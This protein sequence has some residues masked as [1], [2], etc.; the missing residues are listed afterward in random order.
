MKRS[1]V[2]CF[3]LCTLIISPHAF[4]SGVKLIDYMVSSSGLIELLGQ[5]GIKG[6]E[7]KQVESYVFSSL[8]SFGAGK[9]I[10]QKELS[11]IL[12]KMPV[13]GQDASIRKEL[14]L[15]LDKSSGDLKKD[16]V[17][18]AINN[19]IY[20]ANRH[21]KSVIIT[22]A[23]CVSDNLSKSGF[24]FTVENIK[25]AGS[26]KLLNDVIPNNPKDL[27]VF[28]SARV[29]RLGL[30]DYSKVTPEMVSPEEEKTLALFL[31]SYESG[32][33]E[34]KSFAQS[35][36]RLSTKGGKTNLFDASNPNKLWKLVTTDLSSQEIQK[37]STVL[38]EVDEVASKEK[39]KVEDAFNRVLRKKSETSSELLEK[40]KQIK[41]R[42]CFFK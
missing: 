15:L 18:K 37:I 31:A 11:D 41:N 21:G 33:A 4:A 40:Y 38:G 10:S 12:S 36:K 24:K 19:I 2:F 8:N 23:E 25:N 1:L 30:G 5:H 39:L 32:N 29:K 17:V 20:L 42:R 28:I 16:D 27:Q 22:C 13:T 35:V 9:N 7:A 34:F 6:V 14:Q 3:L 26:I